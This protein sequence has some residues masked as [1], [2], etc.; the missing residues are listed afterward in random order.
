M[1][2]T[3]LLLAL[4]AMHLV[5][6][7][8]SIKYEYDLAGNRNSRTIWLKSAIIPKDTTQSVSQGVAV[9]EVI[10]AELKEQNVEFNETLGE[11]EIK[12]YPNPTRGELKVTISSLEQGAVARLLVFNAAG[13]LVVQK[14]D[15]S[16]SNEINLSTQRAGMYIMRIVL[17]AKT[18]E[19]KIVKE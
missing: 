9:P 5:G 7:S 15:L 18:S 12:I 17:G 6:L 8:Q 16:T 13:A 4:L 11:Q 1:K 19:W 2:T 14:E 3:L 10:A